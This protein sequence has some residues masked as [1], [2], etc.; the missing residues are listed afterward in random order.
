MGDSLLMSQV[1]NRLSRNPFIVLSSLYGAFVGVDESWKFLHKNRISLN[2]Q[3]PKECGCKEVCFRKY[4]FPSLKEK[5]FMMT[6][7]VISGA[8]LGYITGPIISPIHLGYN[9]FNEMFEK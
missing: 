6:T 4:Y 9:L 3:F 1:I 2:G 7:G 5:P 8:L